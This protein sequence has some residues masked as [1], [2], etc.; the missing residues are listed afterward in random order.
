MGTEKV[1]ATALQQRAL[2][3]KTCLT[4]TISLAWSPLEAE[5]PGS[6]S[7]HQGLSV[8]S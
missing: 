6:R 5:K 1:E 3:Q 2:W 4:V 8:T 7:P